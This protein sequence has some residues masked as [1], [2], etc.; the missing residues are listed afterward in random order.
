MEHPGGVKI[1]YVLTVNGRRTDGG[2]AFL[3]GFVQRY[4]GLE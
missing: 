1:I 2:L 3:K 4:Q